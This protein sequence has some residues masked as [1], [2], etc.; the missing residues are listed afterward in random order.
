[1]SSPTDTLA[2]P[3]LA[4]AYVNWGRWV[5]DCPNVECNSAEEIHPW[6][7][8]SCAHRE[9]QF[10]AWPETL[11]HC[12][13]CRAMAPIEWPADAADIWVALNRRTAPETRNWFPADHALGERWGRPTGQ[14]P[15]ELIAEHAE[16][17]TR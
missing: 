3:A 7:G 12:S 6:R 8:Y 15:A 1:M 17:E 11:F 16:H 2:V 4:R 13:Y 5:A 10:S 14:T 9:C